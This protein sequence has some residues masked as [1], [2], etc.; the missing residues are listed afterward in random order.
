MAFQ[1]DILPGEPIIVVTLFEGFDFGSELTASAGRTY[2]LLQQ[3]VRPVFLID[4][5]LQVD[6]DLDEL[7]VAASFTSRGEHPIYHHPNLRA[8][9]FVTNSDMVRLAV[10]GLMS[11]TFGNVNAHLFNT[12]DDALRYAR[13]N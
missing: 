11:D 8:V 4:D 12:L 6:M 1:H 2:E 13:S 7:T 9:L 3:A 10:K 5:L